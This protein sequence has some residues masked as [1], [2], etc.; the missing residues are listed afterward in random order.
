MNWIDPWGLCK[1]GNKGIF[2]E[3]Y[4]YGPEAPLIIGYQ[5]IPA[6][7]SPYVGGFRTPFT[8]TGLSFYPFVNQDITPEVIGL[9]SGFFTTLF[10]ENA[11]V[12]VRTYYIIRMIVSEAF[13]GETPVP[14]GLPGFDIP[15]NPPSLY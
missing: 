15:V 4:M 1:E 2:P 14:T 3:G 8:T 10:T 12:G 5:P 13:G 6:N 11:A 7:Y 9:G